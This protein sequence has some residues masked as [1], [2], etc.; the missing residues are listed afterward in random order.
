MN[1]ELIKKY[2]A[3]F[4]HFLNEGKLLTR[5]KS[6][7]IWNDEINENLMWNFEIQDIDIIIN[8]EFSELR[9]A[10]YDG[11]IIQIWEVIKQH[12]SD[13]SKDIYGWKDFKSF[14]PNSPFDGEIHNYRIKPEEQK[15]KAGDFIRH[16]HLKTCHI[17]T[18]I[19]QGEFSD[20]ISTRPSL[21]FDDDFS[22][23]YIKWTP[24]HKELCYFT[25]D[26]NTK[27]SAILREFREIS[28]DGFYVDCFG[29][30]FI[31]CEPFLNS[32]PSW[33]KD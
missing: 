30:R 12:V 15:F 24:S 5:T 23:E 33:F 22:S 28:K 17:V 9:K 21:S 27:T 7:F 18:N 16:R 14:K 13:S 26:T 6:D 25:H 3:E 20:K 32:K 10:L 11:K 29:S 19:N 31:Y 8:D 1:I 2:K 4:D